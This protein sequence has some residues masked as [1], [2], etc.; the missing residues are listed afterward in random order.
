MVVNLSVDYSLYRRTS[1]YK[2][3]KNATYG[4]KSVDASLK[5]SFSHEKRA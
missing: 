2:W 5:P 1:C 3:V 4:K